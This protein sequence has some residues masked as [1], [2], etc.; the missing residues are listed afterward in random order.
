[1]IRREYTAEAIRFVSVSNDQG[2][3]GDTRA[4]RTPARLLETDVPTT[5]L[6]IED[7]LYIRGV[8][9]EALVALVD[10]VIAVVRT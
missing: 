8:V 3:A 5:I 6:V 9:R 7:D 2:Q 4:A 1:M 10:R